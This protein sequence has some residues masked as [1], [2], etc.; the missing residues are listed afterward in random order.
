[1]PH[2]TGRCVLLIVFTTANIVLNIFGHLGP[3]DVLVLFF[4][5]FIHTHVSGHL[6]VM[7]SFHYFHREAGIMRDPDFAFVEEYSIFVCNQP[8][9]TPFPSSVL[10]CFII[11]SLPDRIV[12]CLQNDICLPPLAHCHYGSQPQKLNRHHNDFSV[13]SRKLLPRFKH[14]FNRLV[15]MPPLFRAVLRTPI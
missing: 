3:V 4:D 15:V 10:Q 11:E 7:F 8:G 12:R 2:V 9:D 14:M 13:V 1:M 5:S 6:A